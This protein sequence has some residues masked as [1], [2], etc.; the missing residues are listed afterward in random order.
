MSLC[1]SGLWI[2]PMHSSKLIATRFFPALSLIDE[3]W[4]PG[5]YFIHRFCQKYLT[6]QT[7]RIYSHQ[8]QIQGH[9]TCELFI[10][11][12]FQH[13]LQKRRLL[14]CTSHRAVGLHPLRRLLNVL[15]ADPGKGT[16]LIN[17]TKEEPHQF[18]LTWQNSPCC[19]RI[20]SRWGWGSTSRR[21]AWAPV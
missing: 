18:P 20:S 8:N 15:H 6:I 11:L 12:R 3:G 7:H 9:N 17:N 10:L 13:A 14:H 21:V 1:R 16:H 4:W 5:F 19:S 2:I